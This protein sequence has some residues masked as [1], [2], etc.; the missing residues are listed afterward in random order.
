[1][2]DSHGSRSYDHDGVRQDPN[3]ALPIDRLRELKSSGRIGSVNHR[4]LSFMGSITAPG[5]LV[6]DIAPKAAR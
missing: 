4:H 2:V 6:R 5:K 3:L 1:M